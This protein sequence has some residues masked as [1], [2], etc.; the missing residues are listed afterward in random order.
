MRVTGCSER[1]ATVR[2]RN[3]GCGRRCWAHCHRVWPTDASVT[4]LTAPMR[5]LLPNQMRGCFLI[6]KIMLQ[7]DLPELGE[8][9]VAS[10]DAS[11]RPADPQ[12]YRLD[13]SRGVQ[14]LRRLGLIGFRDEL[15]ML[16]IGRGRWYREDVSSAVVVVCGCTSKIP[17]VEWDL[18]EF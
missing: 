11:W 6:R 3:A 9:S 5:S 13:E 1:R 8:T 10:P 12:R 18:A 7:K 16:V 4:P 17:N 2:G 15:A 14:M